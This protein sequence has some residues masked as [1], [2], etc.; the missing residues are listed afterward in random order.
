MK[1]IIKIFFFNFRKIKFFQKVKECL[2]KIKNDEK[3]EKT[4]NKFLKYLFSV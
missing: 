1:K 3:K 4:K 2:K